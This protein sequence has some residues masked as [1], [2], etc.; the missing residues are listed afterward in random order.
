MG[1]TL[2]CHQASLV[3]SGSGGDFGGGLDVING[4]LG[5]CYVF[6][7][8]LV[9]CLYSFFRC[10]LLFFKCAECPTTGSHHESAVLMR[11]NRYCRAATVLC[12]DSLLG[13]GGCTG[14]E[15]VYSTCDT[16]TTM[17]NGGCE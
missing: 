6:D 4:G 10:F 15:T 1:T 11:V 13:F 17:A 5:T 9:V 12:V 16:A 14:L 8:V 2:T 7:L 3:G